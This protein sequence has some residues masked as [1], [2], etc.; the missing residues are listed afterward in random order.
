MGEVRNVFGKKTAREE[1]ARGVWERLRA[2]AEVRGVRAEE[3]D[4]DVE[5]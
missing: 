1:I 3:V 2:L 5:G 4:V